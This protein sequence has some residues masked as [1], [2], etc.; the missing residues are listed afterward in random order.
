MA[1]I[2]I[3][4][5]LKNRKEISYE[6]LK[7]CHQ[8]LLSKMRNIYEDKPREKLQ[9]ALKIIFTELKTRE[10][11]K[12]DETY[13]RKQPLSKYETRQEEKKKNIIIH[14]NVDFSNCG[15]DK[16]DALKMMSIF[17]LT[18][19]NSRVYIGISLSKNLSGTL[20]PMIR[21]LNL[22]E[23]DNKE[24]Q[25]DWTRFGEKA[26]KIE[27]LKCYDNEDKAITDRKEIIDKLLEEKIDLYNIRL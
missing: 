14:H 15:F 1:V 6:E 3:S 13:I 4:D 7:K 18:A 27:V 24:L 10:E 22:S 2:K 19:P 8:L 12:D 16:S 25:E 21:K 20:Y 5:I 23:Y 26:F 17:K 9:E 11:F